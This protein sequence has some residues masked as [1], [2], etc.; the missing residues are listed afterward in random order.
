MRGPAIGGMRVRCNGTTTSLAIKR[1]RGTRVWAE[2]GKRAAAGSADMRRRVGRRCG[3]SRSV[4]RRPSGRA[5]P[6]RELGRG[7]K[8]GR[9]RGAVRR[10]R[11]EIPV[12]RDHTAAAAHAESAGGFFVGGQS[13]RE[14]VAS[15]TRGQASRASSETRAPVAPAPRSGGGGASSGGGGSHGGGGRH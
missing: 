11:A 14:A 2:W 5:H 13:G 4:H 8:S 6:K 1:P 15:S 7:T 10:W 3:S 9:P 12:I